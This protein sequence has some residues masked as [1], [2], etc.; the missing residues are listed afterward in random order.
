MLKVIN[1]SFPQF[2]EDSKGKKVFLFGCGKAGQMCLKTLCENIEVKAIIDNDRRKWGKKFISMQGEIPIISV[3]SFQKEVVK[4]GLSDIRL[5]ISTI[6]SAWEIVEELD[7]IDELSGLNTYLLFLLRYYPQKFEKI[8]FMNGE[9]KI[10]KIIHYCWFGKK[11]IPEHLQRYI[12][13]WKKICPD[14][15]I[16]RWDESTYDV[17]KNRYMKEAY[18]CGMWGFVPDYARLDIIY[19]YGGIYLDTDVEVCRSL[20][21][22]LCNGA[23]LGA[24]GLNEIS[25]GLCFGAVRGHILIKQLRDYY[26]NKSFYFGDG[27]VNKTP[28]TDYTNPVLKNNGIKIRNEYQ[29]VGNVVVYPSDV[30]A[31]EASYG[32]GK[33]YTENTLTVHHCESSWKSDDE[34]KKIRDMK[35]KLVERGVLD[36]EKVDMF[37]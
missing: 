30:F 10:P 35:L 4:Y 34:K 36:P 29:R 1:C 9:Q 16:I 23:F 15:E 37:W 22:L 32:M 20:D 14:Y 21:I 24:S 12:K 5:L 8:S 19:E 31:P 6:Y 18:D 26:E 28:C 27:S 17:T 25:L 11:E 3:E 33:S 13:T 2:E 7:R